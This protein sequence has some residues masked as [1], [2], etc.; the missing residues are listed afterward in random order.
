MTHKRQLIR[1]AIRLRLEDIPELAGRCHSTR[2]RPTE[3]RELPVAI[4]YTLSENAE[5]IS[6]GRTLM[7]TLS[8]VI[9]IRAS[10]AGAIDNALDDL[11][12]VVE[13]TMALDPTFG[14]KALNSALASTTVGLDGEGE[15]RQAIATLTYNV[16]Y[17][18]DGNGN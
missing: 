13:R 18:T 9:E 5:Q 11:S 12:Q 3:A 17:Q 4:I 1:E 10:A 14:R 7:R 16:R 6:V 15:T 2:S 8:A